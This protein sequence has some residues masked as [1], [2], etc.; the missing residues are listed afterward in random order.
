MLLAGW[1]TAYEP[2]ALVGMEVPTTIRAL[3]AQR[4]R[5]ARGQGEVLHVHLGEVSRWRNHQMWLLSFE[6]LASLVWV[7]AIVASLVLAVLAVTVGGGSDLFGFGLVGG[8]DRDRGD[9]PG[10]RQ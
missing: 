8:R 5:W 6:S 10:A 7:V 2:R 9:H 3:R 4:K 1:H